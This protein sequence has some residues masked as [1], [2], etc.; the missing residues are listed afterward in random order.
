MRKSGKRV[1]LDADGLWQLA[2]KT[3]GARAC[4][5][6]EIRQKLRARASRAED[7][8]AT[9]ARLKEYKYLD[10]RRFAES[11]AVARLENQRL[12]KGR[13]ARDLLRRRVAPALAEAV[14][15]KTYQR[16]DEV[17]LIEEYIR[18]K[19]RAAARAGLFQDERQL[20]SAYRSLMRAGFSTGNILQALKRFAANPDLLDGFEPPAEGE[21]P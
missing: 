16:V 4:S 2:L 8:D 5:T 13:V 19:Y 11:F 9:L 10:D 18:R 6:G 20:G 15:Q 17:A 12:G 14:V 1:P 7:V 21:E 3:L